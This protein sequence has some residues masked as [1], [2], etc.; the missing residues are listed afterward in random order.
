YGESYVASDRWV[1]TN[2]IPGKARKWAAS[3]TADFAPFI[4]AFAAGLNAWANE[5][6]N[7]L[8]VAAQALLPL[9]V[10]DGFA[11]GMRDIHYDW[12]TSESNVMG[13]LRREPVEIHGSNG[14]AIGPAKSVS[15]NAMLL[16]NSHLQWGDN[17]T[18]FEVQLTAPGVTSYGAVWVGFP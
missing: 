3:Q 4:P 18:Y 9:T 2:D 17:D 7:M 15:G 5:H 13:R 1:R 11:H 16:S 8:S 12:L 6:K 10:E 14:W